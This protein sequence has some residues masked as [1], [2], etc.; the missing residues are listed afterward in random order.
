MIETQG[1]VATPIAEVMLERLC[2][3]FGKKIPVE[4][5]AKRG[6]ARFPYGDCELFASNDALAFT[7]R[8]PDAESMAR[9]REVIDLH[10]GMF[11]KRA[12]LRV[13]WDTATAVDDGPREA[14]PG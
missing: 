6:H 3:H 14:P 12:P 7:C 10:V 11:S 9:L 2:K 1:R 5:D 4:H 8:A 13:A